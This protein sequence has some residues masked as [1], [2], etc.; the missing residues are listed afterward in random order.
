MTVVANTNPD[1]T[2]LREFQ[3]LCTQPPEQET[4]PAVSPAH[5]QPLGTLPDGF[6]VSQQLTLSPATEGH[7]QE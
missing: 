5:A 2:N 4:R 7:P 3:L 6:Q 1:W